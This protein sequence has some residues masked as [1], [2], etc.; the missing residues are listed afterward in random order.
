VSNQAEI[1]GY[2]G[3][4]KSGKSDQLIRTVKRAEACGQNVLTFYPEIDSRCKS[5]TIQSR[6]GLELFAYPI[7]CDNPQAMLK[8]LSQESNVDGV[9][10]DEMQFFHPRYIDCIQELAQMGV[11]VTY[12]GLDRDFRGEPF[13]VITKLLDCST[14]IDTLTARCDFKNNGHVCEHPA[15]RTQRLINNQPAS[16][17]SPIVIIKQPNTSVTYEA[18]CEN[19]WQIP[20]LPHSRHL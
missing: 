15:T 10:F 17:N 7:S 20:D 6:T 12:G 8:I 3:P 13:P 14:K 5:L 2:V 1:T 9:V 18:R 11:Q 19:H 4:M 16:Y